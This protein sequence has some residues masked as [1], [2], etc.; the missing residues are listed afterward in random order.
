[1]DRKDAP[2]NIEPVLLSFVRMLRSFMWFVNTFFGPWLGSDV[3]N[4]LVS[5]KVLE[6]YI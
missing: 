6:A 1:M 4:I 5:Q 3:K 2:D